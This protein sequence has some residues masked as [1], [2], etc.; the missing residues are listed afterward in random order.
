[1]PWDASQKAYGL[2]LAIAASIVAVLFLDV[3]TK[4]GM[5]VG[6][7]YVIPVTLTLWT[8]NW[9]FPIYLALLLTPLMVFGFFLKSPGALNI[10]AVN[11]PIII[12]SVYF[13]SLLC[14]LQLLVVAE[15]KKAEED[16][17]SSEE[18]YRTILETLGVG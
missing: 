17:R 8:K 1:M 9:R 4:V 5:A 18:R 13:V 7:L 15:S 16:A 3:Y 12:A 10:A 14:A 11:R 2:Y 6:M